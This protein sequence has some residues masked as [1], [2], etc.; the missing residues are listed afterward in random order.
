MSDGSPK[1]ALGC[2]E[3]IIGDIREYL[4]SGMGAAMSG[5]VGSEY[6]GNFLMIA[7]VGFFAYLAARSAS[8]AYRFRRGGTGKDDPK[9]NF[10]MAVFSLALFLISSW[11]L[12]THLRG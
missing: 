2:G 4:A 5:P 8:V 11:A 3:C 9:L 7:I 6:P 1:A 12:W 10:G